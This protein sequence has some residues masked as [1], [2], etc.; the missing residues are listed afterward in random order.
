MKTTTKWMLVAACAASMVGLGY[1]C[2]DDSKVTPGPGNDAGKD[3]GSAAD[4]VND[5]GGGNDSSTQL[6]ATAQI[7][8]TTVDSGTTLSGT[9]SFV[10]GTDG[11]AI[12]VTLQNA[13]PGYHGL[14]IHSIGDCSGNGTDAGAHFNPTDAG[15]GYPDSGTHHAGDLGNILVNDAGAGTHNLTTKDITLGTGPTSVIN[16]AVIVHQNMDDGVSPNTGDAG[17][18]IGCGV[19]VKQ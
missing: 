6:K 1:G 13:P 8:Q 3:T 12:T 9:A 10:E 17:A 4:V 2:S 7:N 11:V 14:H 19:I 15:H 16:R 18:R 5:T